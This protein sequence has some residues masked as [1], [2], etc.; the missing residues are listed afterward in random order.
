MVK[1]TNYFFALFLFFSIVSFAQSGVYTLNGGSASQNG[2]TYNAT[3]A[4]QSAV[5]V[6]NGGNLELINCT[7]T[8]SGDASDPNSSYQSGVNSSLLSYSQGRISVSGGS[9]SS[10]A[11]GGSGAYA[12]GSGSSITVKNLPITTSKD[13]SIGICSSSQGSLT[14]KGLTVKTSGKNSP[15][16]AAIGSQSSVTIDGGNYSSLST[17]DNNN[18]PAVYCEGSVSISNATLKSSNNCGAIISGGTFTLNNSTLE[19][20]KGGIKVTASFSPNSTLNISSSNIKSQSQETFLIT[21]ESGVPNANF[22]FTGNITASSST[23]NIVNVAGASNANFTLNS[24]TVS[25]NWFGDSKSNASIELKNGSSIS[26]KIEN[27]NLKLDSSSQWS[28]TGESTIKVL[29]DQ[30]GISGLQIT[31]ITGNGNNV[32]YDPNLSENSYLGGLTYSLVNGGYLMPIG[33]SGCSIITEASASPTSGPAPL[34]VSF[35][36]KIVSTNCDGSPSYLWN[37][38]DGATSTEQ[39]TH[40]TYIQDGIYLWR[41]TVTIGDKSSEQ[42]ARVNVDSSNPCVI[43]CGATTSTTSGSPPLTV[44]FTPIVNLKDCTQAVSFF[45]D[46]GDGT[47]STD[48][49]PVHTY[50]QEGKYLYQLTVSADSR[51]C[52]TSGTINVEETQL[53]KIFAVTQATNPYRLK[54]IGEKFISGCTIQINGN[55]VPQTVFKSPNYLIAKKGSALKSMLPKGETVKIQ[56]QNPDGSLSAEFNFVRQ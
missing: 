38:G 19:G 24:S 47:T 6:L 46:F 3:S 12:F 22:N 14:A 13:Y 33:G 20:T 31:N 41:F 34:D 7:L 39:N 56:V 49:N 26:G 4:D 27:C 55:S 8:K 9:I 1:F 16:V 28:V 54:V 53:P 32:Y 45:W 48:E 43:T 50:L 51:T 40:H 11:I 21:D 44:S 10:N 23:S 18:S 17:A 2:Q 5:F 30:V 37:F 42:S 36:G 15:T 25:G 29:S 52:M 35:T